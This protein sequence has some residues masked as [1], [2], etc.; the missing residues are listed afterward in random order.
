M[1]TTYL[2]NKCAKYIY[3][4]YINIKLKKKFLVQGCVFAYRSVFNFQ[5]LIWI[6]NIIYCTNHRRQNQ[7]VIE[8]LWFLV[9][10]YN[11]NYWGILRK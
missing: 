2:L 6:L 8:Y 7:L 3:S 11:S 9:N 10:N 5:L 1:H 4:M